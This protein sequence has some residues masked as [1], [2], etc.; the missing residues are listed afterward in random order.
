LI[1][2]EKDSIRYP[3]FTNT[4]FK[5]SYMKTYFLLIFSIISVMTAIGQNAVNEVA[6]AATPGQLDVTVTTST[7]NGSYAPEN[8]V[9]FWIQDSSGKFVK[10]MLV[11]ANK[12]KADLTNWVTATPIGNSI[13]ATTGATQSS[14]ATRT[15]KWKGTSLAGAV[16]P[17]G[18]YTVK[19]EMT[20][21]NS[22]SRVGTFTFQKGP[23]TQT[24]T[25]TNIPSFSNIAIVWT[26]TPT[27]INEVQMDKLYTVYPN[28]FTS[29]IFVNGIDINEVE[30]LSL[31]GKSLLKS[32]E[33]SVNLSSLVRGTY[34]VQI[35]SKKGSVLKKI[36]KE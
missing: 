33:Q 36:I 11:L 31:S 18:T 21:G 6:N 23:N 26:P 7:A 30:I 34:L 8:I 32:K 29:S 19:M 22:G 17:D 13:D 9:A 25:P 1:I 27:A 20:E 14:H 24:L 3:F 15:G 28:P 10:S 4:L 2:T 5:N 35:K 16:M 12:R